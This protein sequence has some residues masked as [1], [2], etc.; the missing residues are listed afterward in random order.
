MESYDESSCVLRPFP[1]SMPNV[2]MHPRF[3]IALQID[4]LESHLAWFR[5][6]PEIAV[7]HIVRGDNLAWL[8]SLGSAKST[9]AYFGQAYP[10]DLEIRWSLRTAEKRV[11]AKHYITGRL[12]ELRHSNPYHVVDYEAFRQDNAALGQRVVAFLGCDTDLDIV[13]EPK[14]RVQSNGKAADSFTNLDEVRSHLAGL[15]LL[16]DQAAP[17]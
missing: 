15:D 9:G 14:A 5:A 6:H 17:T 1:F 4:R 12:D 13:A 16:L 11:R 3:S 7:V 10:E 8:R 2:C